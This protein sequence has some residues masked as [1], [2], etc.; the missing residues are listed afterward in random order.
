MISQIPEEKKLTFVCR[1]E[2]GC[3]GPQ[4]EKLVARF[5]G[6]AMDHMETWHQ[7]YLNLKI[8]PRIDKALPE[9]DYQIA[10]RGLSRAQANKYL[11][12]FKQNPDVLEDELN[13]RLVELINQYL[14]R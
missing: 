9:F 13:S 7:D 6:F 11:S 4:G 3:L 10:G 5:C 2:G 8:L 1:V 12:I 14:D